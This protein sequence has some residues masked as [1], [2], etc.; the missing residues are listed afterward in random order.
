MFFFVKEIVT[1]VF[2]V[3]EIVT[4]VFVKPIDRKCFF[5]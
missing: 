2:F 3:K 1:H 4:H 5:S